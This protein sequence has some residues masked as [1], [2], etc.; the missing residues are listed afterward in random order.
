MALAL[1]LN[2]EALALALYSV[3]L[4]TSLPA[5]YVNADLV[6]RRLQNRMRTIMAIERINSLAILSIEKA[7]FDTVPI[8]DIIDNN[9][10]GN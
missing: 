2:T 6:L 1:A 5:V 3:A 9:C 10:R 8:A 4:L 7:I